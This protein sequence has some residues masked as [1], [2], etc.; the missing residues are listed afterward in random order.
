MGTG[1][2]ACYPL[3][4]PMHRTLCL[5]SAAALLV[6]ALA[7][8]NPLLPRPNAAAKTPAKPHT[9]KAKQ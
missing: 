5:W 8:G 1:R 2:K 9:Q 3:A 6:G 7:I 4:L